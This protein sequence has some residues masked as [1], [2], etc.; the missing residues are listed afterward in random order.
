ME[1]IGITL[2]DLPFV[3]TLA[4]AE[5]ADRAGVDSLWVP[6]S[7]TRRDGTVTLA[8]LATRTQNC[9]LATGVLNVYTRHPVQALMECATLDEISGGR[10]MLGVGSGNVTRLKEFNTPNVD[11]PLL[12]VREFIEVLRQG[13][14]QPESSYHG[15]IYSFDKIAQRANR[16]TMRVPIYVG[17]HNAQM[18]RLIGQLADGV[19]LSAN[20]VREVPRAIEIINAGRQ[21]AGRTDPVDIAMFIPTFLTPDE[22][23]AVAAAK[24]ILTSF[25]SSSFVRARFRNQYPEFADTAEAIIAAYKSDGLDAA[26]KLVSEQVVH[27]HCIAGNYNTLAQRLADF[28]AAG[29]TRPILSIYPVPL[30]LKQ[31]FA[32]LVESGVREATEAVLANLPQ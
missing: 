10:F 32:P 9:K 31:F 16:E 30:K 20:S 14:S 17:A 19:L 2:R 29:V 13:M 26:V 11:K 18:L 8:A 15:Q 27:D 24:V 21:S 22:A 25:F 1:R 6:E 5:Q 3:E 4:C 28:R 12:Q 23:G 7:I